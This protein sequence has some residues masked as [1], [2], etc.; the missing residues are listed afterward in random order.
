MQVTPSKFQQ[1]KLPG[2]DFTLQVNTNSEGRM[3]T[4]PQGKT[5][6]SASTISKIL[7][8]DAIAAW[9]SRVGEQ[10]ADKKTKRGADRGSA[11]HLICE[12]Y[13]L[14][15]LTPDERTCMFPT[16]KEL[17]LQIRPKLDAHIGRIYGVE[18]AL[19]SDRLRVAG[20]ADAIIEWD[21]EPAIL[22]FK[23]AEKPKPLDWILNYFVQGT[24][25]AEMFEERTGVPAKKV[26]IVM[27]VETEMFPTVYVKPTSSYLPVLER[28]IATYYSEHA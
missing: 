5:Y 15:T 2:L 17:F 23:T 25:Y 27:A 13:L 11:L 28:C 22:D 16:T 19:F 14:G 6:P 9:R 18:Q 1:V 7:T 4:T 10:A 21:G 26:V 24:A 8:R 12:K 20:R 3:Y